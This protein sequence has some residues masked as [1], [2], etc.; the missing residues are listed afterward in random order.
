VEG[1]SPDELVHG[2][3]ISRCS[4]QVGRRVLLGHPGARRGCGG[5]DPWPELAVV[6]EAVAQALWSGQPDSS[7]GRRSQACSGSSSVLQQ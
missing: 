5:A 3:G 4:L 6:D 2:G 1:G 7:G